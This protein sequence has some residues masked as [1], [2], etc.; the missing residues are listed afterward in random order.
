[1]V[2]LRYVKRNT[3]RYIR[4][5]EGWSQLEVENVLQFRVRVLFVDIQG[6]L[7]D[8]EFDKRQQWSEWMDVPTVDETL[9]AQ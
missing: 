7:V 5:S 4:D 6:N 1:M 3:G 2:E 8:P 9:F